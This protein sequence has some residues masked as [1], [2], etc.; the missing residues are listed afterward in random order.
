MKVNE[1]ALAENFLL[2]PVVPVANPARQVP[3]TATVVA[4]ERDETGSGVR[5][6]GAD[7]EWSFGEETLAVAKTEIASRETGIGQAHAGIVAPLP[8]FTDTTA[9][10]AARA[11]AARA[12]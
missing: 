2:N 9:A 6:F 1:I 3:G 8:P 5:T 11:C 7:A 10:L 4:M 12:S